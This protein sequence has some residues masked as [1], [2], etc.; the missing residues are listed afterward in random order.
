MTHKFERS[1]ASY[2]CGILALLDTR[3]AEFKQDHGHLPITI[4]MTEGMSFALADAL[5][6]DSIPRVPG[7]RRLS[8]DRGIYKDIPFYRCMTPNC[9]LGDE[10]VIEPGESELI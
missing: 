9:C 8:L 7:G 6:P 4:H 2:A 1:A 3:I 10:F 5:L